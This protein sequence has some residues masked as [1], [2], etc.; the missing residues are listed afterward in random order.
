MLELL[1][2]ENKLRKYE[3]VDLVGQVQKFHFSHIFDLYI[4]DKNMIVN[5]R[6]TT[7]SFLSVSGCYKTT[8]NIT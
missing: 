3:S 1:Y 5:F 8:Q 6:K 4:L 7:I 2:P